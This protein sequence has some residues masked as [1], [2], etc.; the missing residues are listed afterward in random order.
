MIKITKKVD[1][2]GYTINGKGDLHLT[3]DNIWC[4]LADGVNNFTVS[5]FHYYINCHKQKLK[6]IL[7]VIKWL[8]KN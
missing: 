3:K 5:G 8:N 7:H 4:H 6:V 2:L 1:K